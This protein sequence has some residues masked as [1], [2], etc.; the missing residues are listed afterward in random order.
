MIAQKLFGFVKAPRLAPGSSTVV[1]LPLPA[2]DVLAQVD[3]SLVRKQTKKRERIEET[4]T[5]YS[6]KGYCTPILHSTL[7]LQHRSEQGVVRTGGLG[8]G[9]ATTGYYNYHDGATP[10]YWG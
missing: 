7:P 1:T 3:V 8:R 9:V 6:I 10:R 2:A 4:R 5:Y